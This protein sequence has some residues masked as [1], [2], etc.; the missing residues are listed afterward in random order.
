[1]RAAEEGH[2]DVVNALLAAEANRT[3]RRT[4]RR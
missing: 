1:M 3:R 4:F 2:V